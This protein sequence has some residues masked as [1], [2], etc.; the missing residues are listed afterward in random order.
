MTTRH[1]ILLRGKALLSHPRLLPVLVVFSFFTNAPALWSGLFNDD[2][3]QQVELIES[4]SIHDALNK[5]GLGISR[6]GHLGM[7]LSEHFIAVGPEKNREPFK[8]YGALPWWTGE[9]YQVSLLRPV[10]AFAAWLD[11]KLFGSSVFWRHF[12][13][14]VWLA[15][16]VYGVGTLFRHWVDPPWLAGLA[17]L[18]FALDDNHYFPAM[19]IANR[20]L[21]I[22]LV[23]AIGC[24][25]AHHRWRAHSAWSAGLLSWTF[26]L[27]S[28]LSA[29]AGIA[30]FAYLLAYA[31]VLDRS[32][33]APRLL[34]LLPAFSLI[35]LWR[36]LYNAAGYGASG[37]GFYFD[38]GNQPLAFAQAVWQRGPFMAAGQWFSLPPELFALMHDE[39]RWP[40]ALLLALLSLALPILLLPLLLQSRPARFW[41]V[42]MHLAIVPVCAAIPMGRNLLFCSMGGYALIALFIG[43]C[44]S[45]S[46]RCEPFLRVSP[47][48]KALCVLLIFLHLPVAAL[49]KLSAPWITQWI[50][51]RIDATT[52]LGTPLPTEDQR[53]VVILNAPNPASF[54]YVPFKKAVQERPLPRDIRLLAPGYGPL[55][56]TREDANT[57]TLRAQEASLLTCRPTTRLGMVHLY[58]YLSDF[59]AP[60]ERV[61]PTTPIV[62]PEL[63]LQVIAIDP[64]GNPI[65]VACRFVEPLEEMAVRWLQ[66][67]WKNEQYIAFNP[68]A[69]GQAITI[70]GPY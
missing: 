66:W 7:L 12:H 25:L 54:L 63:T 62:F 10:A 29:E 69:V 13:S 21:L 3:C 47:W 64:Q 30:T 35:L 18:L 52:D 2:Y 5:V 70:K 58:R 24:L 32:R 46:S 61:S 65:E 50:V 28:L 33:W 27:A 36:L 16:V 67:D 23:F 44:F 6:P 1:R 26:L 11:L 39:N 37:G 22:S 45:A 60:H 51:Q 4:P 42:G 40:Y 17:I 38:P 68:P 20:N 41:F 31:L 56:V 9:H 57:L 14:L 49:A 15:L 8:A 19:W 55:T 43:H 34:S 48:A 59:R 53:P